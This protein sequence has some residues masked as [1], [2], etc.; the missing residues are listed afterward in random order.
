MLS[1]LGEGLTCSSHEKLN[2]Y[3]FSVSL[4]VGN[5]SYGTTEESIQSLFEENGLTPTSVRVISKNGES[6]GYVL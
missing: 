1:C 2:I 4:Y 5:L 3:C 6:R